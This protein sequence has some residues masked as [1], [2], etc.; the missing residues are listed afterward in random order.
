MLLFTVICVSFTHTKYFAEEAD[1]VMTI[2]VQA[3]A[4]SLRPYIIVI[5]PVEDLPVGDPGM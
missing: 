1:G 5:E 2:T 4:F 3:S